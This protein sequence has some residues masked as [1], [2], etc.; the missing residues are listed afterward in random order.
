MPSCMAKQWHPISASVLSIT[1]F[2]RQTFSHDTRHTRTRTYAQDEG[3]IFGP[4]RLV[5]ERGAPCWPCRESGSSNVAGTGARLFQVGDFTRFAE[6]NLK[7][8]LSHEDN[9]FQRVGV[10]EGPWIIIP[11]WKRESRACLAR[12]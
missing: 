4:H 6:T 8:G 3:N 5:I 1:V 10:C 12:R 7:D 2:S 9:A 11:I